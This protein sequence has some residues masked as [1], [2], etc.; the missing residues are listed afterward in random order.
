MNNRQ[1]KTLTAIF[2]TP[3]PATRITHNQ[4]SKVRIDL[5]QASLNIHSPHPQKEVKHYAVRLLREFF[6]K[7]GVEP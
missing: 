5:H 6:Q 1:R 4:G 2:S 7:A 3:P